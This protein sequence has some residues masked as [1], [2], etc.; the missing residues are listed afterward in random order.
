MR[1]KTAQD[2]TRPFGIPRLYSELIHP[3]ALRIPT[4]QNMLAWRWS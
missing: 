1:E 2:D 4:L 3:G